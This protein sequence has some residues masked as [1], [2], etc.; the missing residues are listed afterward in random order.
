[1]IDLNRKFR[2]LKTEKEG[3]SKVLK[4]AE[5]AG[6]ILMKRKTL[7]GIVELTILSLEE[8]FGGAV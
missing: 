2:F 4:C 5:I 8:K 1:M 7:I 6:R 3:L